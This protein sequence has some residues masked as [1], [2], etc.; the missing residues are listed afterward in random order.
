MKNKV[1]IRNSIVIALFLL[2]LFLGYCFQVKDFLGFAAIVAVIILPLGDYLGL[3]WGL[4]MSVSGAKFVDTP[5]NK[6]YRFLIL[7]L[8]TIISGFGLYWFNKFYHNFF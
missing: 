1:F 8:K 3:L 5:A 2:L 4:P 7:M 6:G